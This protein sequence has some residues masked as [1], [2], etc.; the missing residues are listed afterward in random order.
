MSNTNTL[1]PLPQEPV[2]HLPGATAPN[3]PIKKRFLVRKGKELV[4]VNCNDI[5][6]FYSRNKLS[7]LKTTDGKNFLVR[8]SLEEIEQ[9]VSGEQFFRVS[10]QVITSYHAI[11]KVLLWF[12]GNL[13]VEL[14]PK[15]VEQVIVS[16]LKAAQ[17]RSWMG[18]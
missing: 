3:M 7:Y 18:E 13:R 17:F 12:N 1:V 15:D 4:P 11:Q 2:Q 9:C 6:Y 14:F 10:R 8:M 5:A 16:R